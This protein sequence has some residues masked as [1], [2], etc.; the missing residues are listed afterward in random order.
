[1]PLIMIPISR[2]SS[3]PWKMRQKRKLDH[4]HHSAVVFNT[5]WISAPRGAAVNGINVPRGAG[6]LPSLIG[7]A[8]HACHVTMIAWEDACRNLVKGAAKEVSASSSDEADG[9]CSRTLQVCG[10]SILLECSR[11]TELCSSLWNSV[12]ESLAHDHAPCT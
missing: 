2:S 8:T 1:M 4:S 11:N 9:F 10:R 6:V 12:P 3:F 7:G 5:A